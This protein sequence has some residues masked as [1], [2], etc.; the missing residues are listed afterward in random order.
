MNCDDRGASLPWNLVQLKGFFIPILNFDDHRVSLPRSEWKVT[1]GLLY[2]GTWGD[3][4]TSLSQ[5]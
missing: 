3:L 5:S 4:D 2:N 1:K